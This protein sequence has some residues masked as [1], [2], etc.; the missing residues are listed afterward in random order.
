M[1]DSKRAVLLYEKAHLPVY[2]FPKQDV[3]MDLLVP[4]QAEQPAGGKGQKTLWSL[5]LGQRSVQDAL[6]SFEQTPDGGPE[7]AGL[8]AMYWSKMDAVFEEEEE[9]WAHARDPHHRI[10]TLRTCRHI[11]VVVNGQ[12]VAETTHAVMLLE[13][14]LPERYYLPKLDCR[15][16][17]LTPRPTVSFCPYKG[18]AGQYWSVGDMEDVAWCYPAPTLPC[19]PI[20]NHIAFFQERVQVYVDGVELPRVKTEWSR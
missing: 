10:E 3:R 19:S 18:R 16:D 7:L 20:A 6:F 4:R 14:S 11:K 17:L 2:Y 9:V 13:T 1:I 5:Q 15:L 8:I 12:T